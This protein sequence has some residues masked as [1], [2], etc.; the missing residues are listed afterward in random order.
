[1]LPQLFKKSISLTIL[2]VAPMML[3]NTVLSYL[4]KIEVQYQQLILIGIG[5][6]LAEI[7]W[8]FVVKPI[9]E[10]IKQ[11]NSLQTYHKTP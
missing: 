1:M 7:G 2:M 11:Q 4:H 8:R 3:T 9:A 6:F 10:K 5:L